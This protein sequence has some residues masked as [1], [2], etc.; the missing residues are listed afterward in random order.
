[1]SALLPWNESARPIGLLS[2]DSRSRKER[3]HRGSGVVMESMH[4]YGSIE[5]NI[6]EIVGKARSLLLEYSDT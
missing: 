5:K 2:E 1:M 4:L 6:Q 3:K